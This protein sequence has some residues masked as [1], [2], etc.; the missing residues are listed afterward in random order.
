MKENIRATRYTCDLCGH[1]EDLPEGSDQLPSS[2]YRVT[3][4]VEVCD[5]Y[6]Y[7]QLKLS[8]DNFDLCHKCFNVLAG[9]LSLFYEIENFQCCGSSIKRKQEKKQ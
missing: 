5:E 1:K 8:T 4:P 3:L 6:G 2:M 9:H 7:K